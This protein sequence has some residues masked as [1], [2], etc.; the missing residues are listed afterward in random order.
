ME[1]NLFGGAVVN[2][3]PSLAGFWPVENIKG[4]IKRKASKQDF[5]LTLINKEKFDKL[6]LGDKIKIR[7][8]DDL[9][10]FVSFYTAKEIKMPSIPSATIGLYYEDVECI[11]GKKFL[12][13]S[14]E[15]A[16]KN[17]DEEREIGLY[18]AGVAELKLFCLGSVI[19]HNMDIPIDCV[20]DKGVNAIKD[21]QEIIPRLNNYNVIIASAG[22]EAIL[23]SVI[24]SVTCRPVLALPSAVGYGYAK[25]GESSILSQLN[26]TSMGI[27][28]FNINNIFGAC[29]CA[30]KINR[31]IKK[32][33]SKEI[34]LNLKG[35]NK[36]SFT[37]KSILDEK[38]F[39]MQ[40][41]QISPTK[42]VFGKNIKTNLTSILKKRAED[43]FNKLSIQII[44]SSHE[45]NEME[46]AKSCKQLLDVN[47]LESKINT[48]SINSILVNTEVL[49]NSDIIIVIS[50]NPGLLPNM[51][52]AL[53]GADTLVVAL[54]TT[55]TAAKVMIQNCVVGIPI[56]PINNS[57]STASFVSL[58]ALKKIRIGIS[59]GPI[60]R[61]RSA[62]ELQIDSTVLTNILGAATRVDSSERNSLS[63]NKKKKTSRKKSNTKSHLSP[64]LGFPNSSSEN[65]AASVRPSAS[66]GRAASA[67]SVALDRRVSSVRRAA[68]AAG[69][70]FKS[71]NKRKYSKG[72]KTQRFR[73]L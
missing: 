51:V 58:I 70:G 12:S 10:Q 19:L 56:M 18:S 35:M 65:S 9:S 43:L 72:R 57:R 49:T 30:G 23:P 22:M 52:G 21:T 53:T 61:S 33:E 15:N 68:S 32:H 50:S 13:N 60:Q 62:P 29:D 67:H 3:F 16:I 38:E 59:S 71:K 4:D 14:V 46:L 11:I 6:G 26:A 73:K 64:L 24:C 42:E 20:A 44:T 36:Y 8:L 55:E 63:S 1:T 5:F 69:G 28:V 37:K 66:V 40:L 47:K 34:V 48:E 2:I 41:R 7:N 17:K 54:P 27:G 25:E 45:D 31:I 39:F